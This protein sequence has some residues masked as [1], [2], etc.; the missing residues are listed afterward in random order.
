M[1]SMELRPVAKH[2]YPGRTYKFYSGPEVLY[3][4]G[5]GLSYTKFLYETSCNGTT[6]RMPVAG[7]HCKGLSYRR[8]A[9]SSFASSGGL[10]SSCQAVNVDGHA[11]QETVSFNVSVTNGGSRDG[12]HAVLVYTVPPPEVADAPIKQ[13]AA[14]RRVFVR[15]GST[16]AEKFTLNVCRAFGVVERTA[17]KVV[18][19]GVS[20]VLVQNGD[21]S[22]FFPEKIEFSV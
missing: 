18:P 2:G 16:V 19:S 5:Y 3:P 7:R 20:A 14:F 22:V 13:V 12:A 21:S 1:T 8:S 4:F 11:C 17:N 6:V 10:P 9:L 15:A